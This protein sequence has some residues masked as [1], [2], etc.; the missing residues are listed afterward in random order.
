MAGPSRN[1]V[2]GPW[3]Q[4]ELQRLFG[5]ELP[6]ID[7]I[8]GYVSEQPGAAPTEIGSSRYA[9]EDFTES[10]PV[11]GE[12]YVLSTQLPETAPQ[13][14]P[15]RRSSVQASGGPVSSCSRQ[16]TSSASTAQ[17]TGHTT[18]TGGNEGPS[19]SARKKKKLTSPVWEDFIVSFSTNTDGS[20]ERWGTCKQ[21]GKKI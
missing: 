9:L 14:V 1:V 6:D 18:V 2:F 8:A 11:E 12:E 13:E 10:Q 15:L 17:T 3:T 16:G 4:E 7:L 20:E 21:C 5:E 19:S